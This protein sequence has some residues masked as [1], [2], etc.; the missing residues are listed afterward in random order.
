MK[1]HLWVILILAFSCS[2][3]Q[4]QFPKEENSLDRKV[5]AFLEENANNWRDMNVPLS[6]GKILYDLIIENKYTQAVEIGTST[7]HSAI[8]IAWALSK[9]GGK[10]ITIEIDK[11]RYVQAKANFKKA[12][13]HKYIDARLADAHELVPQLPGK[14]DF[15]FSDADKFWYKNY[16]IDM[17][18][19]LKVGGCFAAHNT[20]MRVPGVG[21]FLE[22]VE[23]LKNYETTFARG[24]RSGISIS[25]KKADNTKKN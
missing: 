15:V 22:Y 11:E 13:V 23:S 8:W 4:A 3:T 6:D 10:L 18:P 16:F 24:S 2:S 17:D 21:D 14:Y 20:A 1:L 12:G 19:K 25:L 9:T 5:K 7:G